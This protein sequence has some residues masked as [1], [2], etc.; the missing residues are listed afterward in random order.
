M[1]NKIAIAFVCGALAALFRDAPLSAV[2]VF[3]VTTLGI[4][5][6][7]ARFWGLYVAGWFLIGFAWCVF[8][9]QQTVKQWLPVEQEGQTILVS[10]HITDFPRSSGEGWQFDFFAEELQGKVR[11]SARNL[12]YENF[13]DFS[14]RYR[15]RVK[16]KQP[17]GLINFDQ[18]DY[19]SWLLQA[20]YRATGYVQVIDGCEPHSP[21]IFLR[22]RKEVGEAILGAKLSAY[23][24]STLSALLIGNYA[25]I[26]TVQWR[27]L[28]DSGTIHLLSVSGLHIVLVAVLFHFLFKKLV[29]VTVIPLRYWPADHWAAVISLG[30]VVFYAL[31]TG[32][33]VATQRSL[34]MVTVAVLQR[35][36]YGKFQLSFIFLASLF[37]VVIANPLSMLSASFWF[38]YVATAALMLASRTANRSDASFV[39][40]YVIEPFRLQIIMFLVMMPVL[41]TVYGRVSLLSLPL[42]ILAVPW[43]SF[44]S[45]PCGF[46]ALALMPFSIELSELM[47]R[48]SGWTLDVY[49]WVM[50]WLLDNVTGLQLVMGGI[51]RNALLSSMSGIGI[52]CF[53]RFP[54]LWRLL[55]LVL[56]FPLLFSN[57]VYLSE[58]EAEM[59]VLDVGQGL[60]VIVRTANHVM[61]YDTGDKHSERFDAGRDIVATALRNLR[62]NAINMLV[63]SHADSDHAGGRNGLLSEL[64]ALQKWSGTPEQLSNSNEY[65]PCSAGMHWRWDGVDFRVLYPV[66]NTEEKKSDNNRSCVIQVKAGGKRVLLTGDIEAPAEQQILMTGVDIYSDILVAPHHGSRTSSSSDFLHAVNASTVVVSAGYK[67]HF[68]HPASVV[69]QRYENQGMA[70]LNTAE[71][72]AVQIHLLDSGV[73][74]EKALCEQPTF[75]REARYNMHCSSLSIQP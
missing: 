30:F 40:R 29:C 16:L 24:S 53:T 61:V 31:I 67:N 62:V 19:Q 70:L 21:D 4:G 32:F 6:I 63:I 59:T 48:I 47:L 3:I 8:Y 34:I 26:D 9:S 13:P 28:R 51:N 66:T 2:A 58:Q 38:T 41:L 11:L 17:R 56:C 15:F 25:D 57:G 18:Y 44:V 7:G 45:L 42:N 54:V 50:K 74:I 72:G 39:Y 65:L 20:G 36:F 10:G 12:Q 73:H 75:W 35:I 23:A 5:C 71:L 64:P 52:L 27:V 49:W 68:R 22:I 46:A 33:S 55:G 1:F 14:C 60:A 43:V 37:I 69:R